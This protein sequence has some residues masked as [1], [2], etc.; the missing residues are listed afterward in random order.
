M[1]HCPVKGCGWYGKAKGLRIH[2]ARVHGVHPEHDALG[3]PSPIRS[4]LES[5]SNSSE[6]TSNVKCPVIGCGKPVADLLT[7]LMESHREWRL[8]SGKFVFEV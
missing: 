4:E 6:G 3:E 1:A 7:H 2:M 5:E 8:S